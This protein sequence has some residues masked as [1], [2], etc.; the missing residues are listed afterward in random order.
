MIAGPNGAGKSTFVDAYLSHLDL[1]FLN[2]DLL[3]SKVGIDAYQA[4]RQI[5]AI[6]D[7]YIQEGVG[8]ITETVFSD[9]VGEKVSVLESAVSKGF[10]VDLIYIGIDSPRQSKLRVAGRVAAGGHDVPT[11]K[12]EGR[13][14][15]SLE[16]LK[17]AILTLPRVILYDNSSYDHP[18][19]FLAEYRNGHLHRE[20][21][22]D[23][24]TWAPETPNP[25]IGNAGA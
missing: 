2:A 16:N 8:F 5:A 7:Q 15:R 11:E 4:A 10:N 22:Q 21:P 14:Y 17:R 20:S 3:A 19:R 24:P 12:L 13:Y 18:Y 25:G 1:P 9:P 6:R 23:K